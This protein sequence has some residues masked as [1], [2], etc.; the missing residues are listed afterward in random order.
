[1]V[2]LE[3]SSFFI[4]RSGR[5]HGPL[6]W[7][8]VNSYLS[9]GSLKPTDLVCTEGSQDWRPALEWKRAIEGDPEEEAAAAA[10]AEAELSGWKLWLHKL[11]SLTKRKSA[12]PAPR[13]RIVR[14]REWQ[15]VP[16]DQRSTL[17]L[18]DLFLGF[19]FPPRLWSACTHV[20]SQ[21]IFRKSKDEA[22]YLK[23]WPQGM[24]TF[25]T[26][27]IIINALCWLTLIATFNEHILPHL[28][29]AFDFV[30]ESVQ[31]WLNEAGR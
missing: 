1:M 24:E 10:L 20:F 21:H 29:Q 16:E 6:T 4:A 23:I 3:H 12:S 8:E 30:M 2:Q 14:F 27:L 18:R 28:R 26:V 22:G 13:R 5:T 7:S 31:T 11:Q 9:Y 25:C 17:I 15:H 19:F